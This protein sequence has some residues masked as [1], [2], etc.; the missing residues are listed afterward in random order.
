MHDSVCKQGYSK[1]VNSLLVIMPIYFFL[2]KRNL[3]KKGVIVVI[4]VLHKI[5]AKCDLLHHKK[6]FCLMHKA[7]LHLTQLIGMLFDMNMKCD[8]SHLITKR[9][10]VH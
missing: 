3:A 7:T 2:V 8:L 5:R 10:L 1:T 4:T 9:H 6:L